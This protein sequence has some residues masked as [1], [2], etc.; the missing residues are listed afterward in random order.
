MNVPFLDLK[1]SNSQ[2]WAEIAPALERMACNAQF[3]LG[4]AVESFEQ[5]FAGFCNTKHCIGVNNGTSA[6]HLALLAHEIGPG[7]EVITTPHSWV[8]T[9]WA[10]EYTGAKPVFVDI[11]PLT[12]NINPYL[13]ET[14]ITGR[15]KAVLPVHLYGHAADLG[16]LR[17]L[18]NTYGLS[19]IEDA[20]QAH[21]AQHAGTTVGAVGEAGCFSFYPGKNLGSFGEAGAVVTNSDTVA[22]RI[23][24]LRDHAQHGRHHHIALG[25]NYRMEAI[26]GLVLQH[27]LTK[28][29]T[30][31]TLRRNH[32]N[33]YLTALR[34]IREIVLPHVADPSAH[35]WHLFVILVSD[36]DQ[37]RADL[38]R[39][40]ISTGVH[41]PTLIPYQ[42]AFGR[43]GLRPG[44]FPVADDVAARCVSLPMYPELTSQQREAVV[45]AIYNTSCNRQHK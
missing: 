14:A 43:H 7:D 6:L 16:K 29:A 1:Q 38:E 39:Q 23:R 20:A 45:E 24:C 28:L 19:L 40:G 15:T 3:I 35:V 4:P 22:E 13:V 41:Y 8:S 27:K 25:Y 18:C 2:V 5:Q 10:V 44:S 26:H 11:D 34:D 36:R 12:Y 32:A 30:W 42:P 9:S 37:F 31:N 33:Y 21:G 17:A